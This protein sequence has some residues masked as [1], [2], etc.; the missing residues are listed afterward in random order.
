M[1]NDL[2]KMDIGGLYDIGT[3]ME[4]DPDGLAEALH[5]SIALIQL[6]GHCNQD[7]SAMDVLVQAG[8]LEYS[9]VETAVEMLNNYMRKLY[10]FLMENEIYYK[11]KEE[12]EDEPEAA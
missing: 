3:G 12:A 1:K 5:V 11:P 9:P 4:F 2:I 8:D 6:L 7:E 10:R